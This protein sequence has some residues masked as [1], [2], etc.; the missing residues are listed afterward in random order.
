MKQNKVHVKKE[1]ELLKSCIKSLEYHLK[2]RY[3]KEE[4]IK[5]EKD[6]LEGQL[7]SLSTKYNK[8]K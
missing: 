5:N 3:T 2:E 6:A 8:V 7:Q 4:N 1:V